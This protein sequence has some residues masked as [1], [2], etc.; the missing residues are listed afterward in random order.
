MS[1]AG[2]EPNSRAP[3]ERNVECYL[4]VLGTTD[5]TRYDDKKKCCLQHDV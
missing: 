1:V 4:R 3:E 5:I 2:N